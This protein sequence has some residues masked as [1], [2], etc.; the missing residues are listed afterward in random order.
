MRFGSRDV[1]TPR[2]RLTTQI[3]L[4]LFQDR[5]CHLVSINS[6]RFD[7]VHQ[8]GMKLRRRRFHP[9]FELMQ[10]LGPVVHQVQLSE[11]RRRR[12]QIL[13]QGWSAANN[14]GV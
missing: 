9:F 7:V 5:L 13:A 1:E 14:P 6:V 4:L 2:S 10:Y 8:V 3:F 11:L 12:S